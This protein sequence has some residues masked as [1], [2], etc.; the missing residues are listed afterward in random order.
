MG[1]LASITSRNRNT[2]TNQSS[3]ATGGHAIDKNRV[4]APTD[5]T[6]INPMN[7]GT[8]ESVRTAPVNHTPRYFSKEEADALKK[9]AAHTSQGVIQSQ[10]AYQALKK[11]EQSD[12]QVHVAHRGY[13]RSV[14]DSEL[15]KKRADTVTATHLHKL[16]PE[17][18][19]LGNG[20]D[21]AENNAQKRIDELKAKVKEQY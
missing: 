12:S 4:L 13:I 15:N 8:W 18:A 14:A 5:Q 3:L 10:R 7:A 21:R 2:R 17:Y 19:K 1:V 9:L 20:I 16:R 6:V 11:I